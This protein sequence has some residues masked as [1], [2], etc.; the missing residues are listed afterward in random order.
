[1]MTTRDHIVNCVTY[2]GIANG[3]QNKHIAKVKKKYRNL[4]NV[5]EAKRSLREIR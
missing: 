4:E 3:S 2:V 1:M 5:G